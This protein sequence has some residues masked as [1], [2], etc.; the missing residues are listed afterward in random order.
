M[1]FVYNV[2]GMIFGKEEFDCWVFMGNYWDVW[3]FG[4]VDFLSG[5]V[6]MMEVLCGLGKL[7]NEIDWWFRR[8]IK[9]CSWGVEEYGLIGLYE[10]VEENRNMLRDKVVMYLNVD[11]VVK[12]N[13][14]FGVNGNFFLK[15]FVYWE[16]V[17][18]KDFNEWEKSVSV[19]DCWL[20]KYFFLFFGKF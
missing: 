16:I 5:L 10:W 17:F 20:K 14:S 18:V 8:M 12:G 1:L 11:F 7:L 9:F 13:Y 2:I 3:V 6:V 19:Y 4:G 15:L